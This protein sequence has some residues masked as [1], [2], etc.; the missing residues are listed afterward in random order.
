MEVVELPPFRVTRNADVQV[1]EDGDEDLLQALEE[2][3]R[4]RRFGP[5]VRLEVDRRR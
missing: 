2:E 3:L 5:P 4:R 1:E